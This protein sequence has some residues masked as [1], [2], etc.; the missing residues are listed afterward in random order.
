[1]RGIC[2][3]WKKPWV[4]NL[5]DTILLN[6]EA[7]LHICSYDSLMYLTNQIELICSIG[8]TSLS[9]ASYVVEGNFESN[10]SCVDFFID[11]CSQMEIMYLVVSLFSFCSYIASLVL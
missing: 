6:A 5:N 8:W 3:H 11:C 7:C 10:C 9:D 1:M 2:K 4:M